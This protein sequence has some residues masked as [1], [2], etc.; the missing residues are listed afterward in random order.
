MS[1]AA[2]LPRD[3]IVRFEFFRPRT[4]AMERA[5]GVGQRAAGGARGDAAGCPDV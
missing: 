2:P 5:P 3:V 1:V 4:E